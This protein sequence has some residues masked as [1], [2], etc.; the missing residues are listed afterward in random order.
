MAPKK[1]P[2][3]TKS[4]INHLI[5]ESIDEAI[6]TERERVRNE[7]NLEVPPPAPTPAPTTD[8]PTNPAP[9]AMVL[10]QWIEKSKSVFDISNCAKGNKVIFS[11]A[12]L[13]DSALTR[14]NNQVASMGR[15]VANRKSWTEMKAMMN[16]GISVS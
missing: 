9:G 2:A 11:A 5:Q 16:G 14:W 15:A 3:L 1:A 12:T 4:N 8:P 10:S 6:A 13:Q 7:N